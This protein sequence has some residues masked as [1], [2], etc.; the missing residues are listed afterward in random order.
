MKK[1]NIQYGVFG[2][3]GLSQKGQ[4]LD[5]SPEETNVSRA[6][7]EHSEARILVADRSKLDRLAPVIT[8]ALIDVDF[9]VMDFISDPIRQLCLQSEITMFEVGSTPELTSC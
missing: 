9:L 3:G 6:I 5:F 8:G 1:F 2:V 7:I 4:L